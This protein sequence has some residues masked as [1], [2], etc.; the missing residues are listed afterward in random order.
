MAHFLNSTA[1]LLLLTGTFSS[2]VSTDHGTDLDNVIYS[3]IPTHHKMLIS[4]SVNITPVN[5]TLG[6]KELARGVLLGLDYFGYNAQPGA[7]TG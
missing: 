2:P 5:I 6:I 1:L 3:A 7:L 4:L